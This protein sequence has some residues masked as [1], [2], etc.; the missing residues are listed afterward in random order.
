MAKRKRMR[1]SVVKRT[2]RSRAEKAVLLA[3]GSYDA[4]G[5]EACVDAEFRRLKTAMRKRKR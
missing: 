3:R 1:T 5:F 4:P 2:L